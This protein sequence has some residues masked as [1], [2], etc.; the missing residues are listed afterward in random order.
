MINSE[1]LAWV[2]SADFRRRFGRGAC[3]GLAKILR[4][5][6]THFSIVQIEA[7]PRRPSAGGRPGAGLVTAGFETGRTATS[8]KRNSHRPATP[9]KATSRTGSRRRN[10]VNPR[11]GRTAK[12][13]RWAE[14]LAVA[15]AT[16]RNGGSQ[17]SNWNRRDEVRVCARR[18]GKHDGAPA[19]RNRLE[20][21][22]VELI[23]STA[24]C[25]QMRHLL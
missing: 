10:L 21:V 14:E 24:D 16:G 20:R 9:L 19:G 13:S 5:G 23:R 8:A 1:W 2:P 18:F 17:F 7:R 22:K 4:N 3:A 15:S 25:P 11:W 12:A 6:S